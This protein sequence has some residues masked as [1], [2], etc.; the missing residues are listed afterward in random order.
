MQCSMAIIL[1]SQ[2]ED[3][4]TMGNESTRGTPTKQSFKIMDILIATT[5]AMGP[6]ARSPF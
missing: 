1:A 6:G 5:F 4:E 2:T 3:L